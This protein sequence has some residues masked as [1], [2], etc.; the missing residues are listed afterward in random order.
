MMAPVDRLIG[1]LRAQ[2]LS[3]GPADFIAARL[4]EA[5]GR[6]V[7]A[8]L[9]FGSHKTGADPSLES[10]HDFFI[11][12]TTY[13]GFYRALHR[14]GHY[15]GNPVLASFLN[16]FLPPNLIFTTIERE[17]R[18]YPVKGAVV[19][20][21][22]F[23]RETRGKNRDHFLSARLFQ[24]VAISFC[25]NPRVE[26]FVLAGLAATARKTLAWAKPWLPASFGLSDFL[27][28]LFRISLAAE[29]KPEGTARGEALYQAQKDALDRIYRDVLTE[30]AGDGRLRVLGP[31]R[32]GFARP[33]TAWERRKS[34]FFFAR[35]KVRAT[36]RWP[37]YRWTFAGWREYIARKIERRG[38]A[39]LLAF[40]REKK[41]P[42]ILLWPRVYRSLR[43]RRRKETGCGIPGGP[44]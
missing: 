22:A 37:K 5:G 36:A 29:I 9:Y 34:K 12:V 26:G 44:S 6:S 33:A 32:Y 28:T 31:D 3:A 14:S 35:S 39:E 41:R 21:R 30:A 43:L 2:A 10:A 23:E 13:A 8:V 27:R 15:S 19:S 7:Q 40:L 18:R 1:L 16:V 20:V 4:A 24:T 25:R 42:T 11:V 38:E 17:G